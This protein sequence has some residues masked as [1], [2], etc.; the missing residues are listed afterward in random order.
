MLCAPC[1]HYLG[2]VEK[3]WPIPTLERVK[4]YLNAVES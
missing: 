4:E 2:H 3:G 1:N